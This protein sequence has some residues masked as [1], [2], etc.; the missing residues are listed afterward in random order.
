MKKRKQKHNQQQSQKI[1]FAQHKNE[2]F[3]RLENMFKTLNVHDVF[4]LIPRNFLEIIYDMRVHPVRIEAAPG[5]D[6][7]P[8][9]IENTKTIIH[10]ILTQRSVTIDEDSQITM[11]LGVFYTIFAS[12]A[13]AKRI[14]DDNQLDFPNAKIISERLQ[15]YSDILTNHPE[16]SFQFMAMMHVQSCIESNLCATMYWCSFETVGNIKGRNGNFRYLYIHSHNPEKKHITLFNQSRPVIRVGW[17]EFETIVR[18]DALSLTAEQLQLDSSFKNIKFSVYIQSHA[19]QRMVERLDGIPEG[20]L[21]SFLYDSIKLEFNM[22]RD[23]HGGFLLDM[24]ILGHK[25]GYLLADIVD[26]D[27]VIRTFLF[28]T[29]AG[30]PEGEKLFKL[31]GLAIEDTKYLEINKLST[32]FD[33]DIDSNEKVKEIFIN[34]GCESLFKLNKIMLHDLKTFKPKPT[35]ELI[36]KYLGLSE[37]EEECGEVEEEVED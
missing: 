7:P 12:V 15:S 26:T 25:V 16:A 9:L 29:N 37:K 32:F 34:A 6:I 19:L 14:I 36:L 30:T 3:R 4:L 23:K 28:I 31:T 13:L 24:C 2:F 33:S 1:S 8:R 27:L 22:Q 10:Q 11:T 21:H 17:G 18:Y 35:A 5:A 20:H